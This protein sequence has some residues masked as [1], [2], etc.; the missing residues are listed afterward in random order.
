MAFPTFN[1]TL[2]AIDLLSRGSPMLASFL[3]GLFL[4]GITCPSCGFPLGAYTAGVDGTFKKGIV[5]GIVFNSG[6]ILFFSVFG[7]TASA[8]IFALKNPYLIFLFQLIAGTIMLSFGLHLI[9]VIKNPF[10]RVGRL[11]FGKIKIKGN[12]NLTL[13]FFWGLALSFVC[14]LE[15][16]GPLIF[17]A[18]NSLPARNLMLTF[19]VVL[20]FGIG[21]MI[22]STFIAGV[23]GGLAG[24]TK[25]YEWRVR[26]KRI[27]GVILAYIGTV[28]LFPIKI[29][30]P[31][32][33]LMLG[34]VTMHRLEDIE[35]YK[36]LL[37]D[38]T[39]G[40]FLGISLSFS[41]IYLEVIQISSSVDIMYL[42][43]SE[44]VTGIGWIFCL[45]SAFY[46]VLNE[47]K[48]E[49]QESYVTF[50]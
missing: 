35:K 26:T 1:E 25:S 33:G 16:L 34:A 17:I 7:I 47:R 39:L 6:R 46:I 31:I 24:L 48:K 29:L 32:P 8:L 21:T 50:G 11:F 41:R 49:I 19:L 22:P 37:V 45:I 30:V 4:G 2:T 18:I 28:F 13:V 36:S 15:L 20:M 44:M 43:K 10:M 3:A 23:S 27:A 42:V 40:S 14:G 12:P 9:G 5:T 38:L